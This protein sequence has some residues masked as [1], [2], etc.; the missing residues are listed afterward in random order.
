MEADL[1][2]LLV[3]MLIINST[4]GDHY[5]YCKEILDF[6][7]KINNSNDNV[8]KILENFAESEYRSAMTHLE[9]ASQVTN[10][11]DLIDDS[12]KQAKNCLINAL[13]KAEKK[14]NQAIIAFY[15]AICWLCL[16]EQELAIQWFLKGYE[17]SLEIIS[18]LML[19]SSIY[20]NQK[21][22]EYVGIKSFR[23]KKPL[24][25]YFFLL[26][27]YILQL[28]EYVGIKSFRTKETASNIFLSASWL[29]LAAAM[30]GP[31]SIIIF[32]G[33]SFTG[34]LSAKKWYKGYSLN[35]NIKLNVK[36]IITIL[37]F[38]KNIKFLIEE[39]DNTPSK[40]EINNSLN[41]KQI[42]VDN[43]VSW[44][45]DIQQGPLN[46]CW[47]LENGYSEGKPSQEDLLKI[48]NVEWQ[49]HF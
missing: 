47:S 6:V 48:E 35:K 42:Y 21:S 43:A 3:S 25:I 38:V 17:L 13:G 4:D 40:S 33:Y 15:I 28:E 34:I 11:Y 44:F 30:G 26:R 19:F 29:Y 49:Q 37:K 39:Q 27:G 10:N 20:L 41:I 31:L 46:G 14:N 16:N 2:K 12:I 45:K 9:T 1:A 24:V 8:Q 36:T 7:F 5:Q 32:S 18:D 23:T 22:E